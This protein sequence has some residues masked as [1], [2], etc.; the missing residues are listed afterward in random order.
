[1][2]VSMVAISSFLWQA[3]LKLSSL[4]GVEL[5]AE[6]QHVWTKFLQPSL[7]VYCEDSQA[8]PS[9]PSA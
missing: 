5:D 9:L 1:M 3:S 4:E 8:L 6:A 7:G 2:S